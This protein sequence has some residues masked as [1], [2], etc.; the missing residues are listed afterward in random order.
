M[1]LTDLFETTDNEA[2]M[3]S[4]V[5]DLTSK[6]MHHIYNGGQPYHPIELGNYGD[7][8]VYRSVEDIGLDD[9]FLLLIGLKQ[10]EAIGMSGMIMGFGR[11]IFGYDRGIVVYCMNEFTLKNMYTMVN[12]T[13]FMEVIEHEFVHMLD[14]DR[15]Q[16]GMIKRP[17][18]D[19]KHK[20][21]YYN[22][23]AEFNAYFFDIAKP[24]LA[25]IRAAKQEPQ[26][27]KDYMALYGL[28]GDWRDDLAGVLSRNL[29]AQ[30]FV[31][32]LR[33]DRRRSLIKRLYRL[34]QQMLNAVHHAPAN[35]AQSLPPAAESPADLATAA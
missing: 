23:P 14:N 3:H 4:H 1:Q 15:T 22:D 28:T 30:H 17:Y 7:F 12:T 18:V 21:Q 5:R 35:A 20:S 29:P 25:V 19:A 6:V 24:M 31:K 32:H 34:H 16:G 11:D 26:D 8:F 27:A 2:E 9:R 10:R 33:K 13:G